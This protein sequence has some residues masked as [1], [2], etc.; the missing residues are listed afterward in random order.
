MNKTLRII[1]SSLGLAMWYNASAR[2]YDLLIPHIDWQTTFLMFIVSAAILVLDDGE[3]LE[4][5]FGNAN[6]EAAA[7]QGLPGLPSFVNH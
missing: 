1:I 2:M 7:G 6:D 5:V 3:L 4:L